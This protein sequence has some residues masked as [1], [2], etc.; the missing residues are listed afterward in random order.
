MCI[1]LNLGDVPDKLTVQVEHNGFF[2]GL[3]ENL[4]YISGTCDWFD[5]Y[6]C[7]TF[8]LLWIQDFL[9]KLGHTMDARTH[10]Y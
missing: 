5:N 2:S 4:C 7:N 9:K 6:N 8:S 10:V 1:T 3:R